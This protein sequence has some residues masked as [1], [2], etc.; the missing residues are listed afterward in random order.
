MSSIY[1][2]CDH[3]SMIEDHAAGHERPCSGTCSGSREMAQG[4]REGGTSEPDGSARPLAPDAPDGLT[5]GPEDY[6]GVI[7]P[8]TL[9]TIVRLTKE[10]DD[11]L[12]TIAE[13]NATI[14]RLGGVVMAHVDALAEKDAT[15]ERLW[16]QLNEATNVPDDRRAL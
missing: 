7:L 9:D 16:A 12:A 13:Q 2:C 5:S 14:G 11:A 3:C 6:T 10:R 15:I 8:I 4:L 1:A